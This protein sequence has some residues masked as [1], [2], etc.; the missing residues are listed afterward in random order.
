MPFFSIIIP[1]Y[2]RPSH[3][4]NIIETLSK[5]LFTDFEIIIMDDSPSDLTKKAVD[6][7]IL[8]NRIKYFHHEKFGVSLK[9]NLGAEKASGRYFVFLDD[10]D[11]VTTK[12]LN[13]FH[14]LALENNYPDLLFCNM[15]RIVG[16]SNKIITPKHAANG[17]NGWAI[18]IPGGWVVLSNF[19]LESG[20][21]DPNVLYGENS[22]LFFRF[23][24]ENPTYKYTNEPNFIYTPSINGG[25]KN[26]ENK[27]YSTLY[28]LKKHKIYFEKNTKLRNSYMKVAG[29]AAAKIGQYNLSHTI[30]KDALAFNKF[31]FKL[32][33]FYFLTLSATLT[34]FKWSLIK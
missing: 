26:F 18:I 12:W 19:F 20:G 32:W 21:F 17:A 22:E 15:V 11:N 3:I 4:S 27:L 10:D 23:E 24:T 5:Q 14:T 34:R 31:N 9:R 30:F 33:I 13:A 16:N 8:D 1:T 6:K 7:Y 29:V 2:N 25:S 28:V